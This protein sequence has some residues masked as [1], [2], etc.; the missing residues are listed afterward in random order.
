ML[1]MVMTGCSQH[2][3]SS[4][5]VQITL[6]AESVSTRAHINKLSDLSGRSF[7]VLAF[8]K[9]SED[10]TADDR[11]MLRNAKAVCK[12]TGN[13]G[14]LNLA[15]TWFYPLGGKEEFVF[16]S[17]YPYAEDAYEQS[18]TQAS[19]TVPV[20][21]TYDVLGAKAEVENGFSG[22]YIL[23]GGK[24]PSF[25][26]QHKTASISFKACK[27]TEDITVNIVN[28]VLANVPTK[29]KLC[30]ADIENPDNVGTFIGY[31]D[32]MDKQATNLAGSGGNLS[33][34]EFTTTPKDITR[35]IYIAPC[36]E[37]KIKADVR[38]GGNT[39]RNWIEFI[40]DPSQLDIIEGENGEKEFLA[41]HHYTFTLKVLAEGTDPTFTVSKD[42]EEDVLDFEENKWQDAFTGTNGND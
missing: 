11:L 12:V 38:I 35:P 34:F 30:V 10:L 40:I 15:Q 28:I 17:Y 42:S 1:V 6:G 7:G 21:S 9:Y 8:D 25:V 33:S 32:Y 19:I 20:A 14:L 16:Y 18:E 23:T 13:R 36:K 22:Y 26:Y 3:D 29:A 37:L 27:D 41:G 31:S 24:Q 5:P 2:I 39:N 4:E